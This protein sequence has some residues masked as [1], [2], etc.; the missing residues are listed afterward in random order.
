MSGPWAA[1]GRLQ[2]RAR[3]PEAMQ[4][5]LRSAEQSEHAHCHERQQC[6]VERSG[7]KTVELLGS[8]RNCEIVHR[9]LYPV[10]SR[11]KPPDPRR[12]GLEESDARTSADA[13]R[14]KSIVSEGAECWER[15]D[16][17]LS[18]CAGSEATE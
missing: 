1:Q 3:P 18:E 8:M 16:R 13:E 15:C 6:K 14:P 4:A 2:H 7:L 17:M 5:H 11:D 10:L 9:M 12:S